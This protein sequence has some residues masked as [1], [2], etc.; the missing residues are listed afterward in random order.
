LGFDLLERD[1]GFV[2]AGLGA[3][4]LAVYVFSTVTTGLVTLGFTA[5]R[6]A[7]F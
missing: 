6:A 1:G 2:L 5:L 7:W 3:G 4:G